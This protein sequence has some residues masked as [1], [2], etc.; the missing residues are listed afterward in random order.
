MIIFRSF[1]AFG[2]P[3]KGRLFMTESFKWTPEG[4][5]TW[6]TDRGKRPGVVRLRENKTYTHEL[7][8]RLIKEKKQELEDGASRRDAL[9]LVGPSCLATTALDVRCNSRRFS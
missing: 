1:N 8:A 9:S 7:A 6:I 5:A 4:F 2:R 3:S